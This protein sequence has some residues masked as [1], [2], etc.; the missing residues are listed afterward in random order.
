MKSIA[1]DLLALL[2]E[3]GGALGL[4]EYV[5][6][7][8]LPESGD[9]VSL[10]MA[11]T[12]RLLKSYINGRRQY[13]TA[14]NVLARSD[15]GKTSEVRLKVY[16][17]LSAVASLFEGMNRFALSAGRTILT[18]EASAPSIVSQTTDGRI[19]YSVAITIEY[20]EKI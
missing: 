14:F 18:G 9:G 12:P 15:V 19:T 6:M 2:V 20:E 11:G 5:Q 1:Y 10:Q 17:W 4:P 7:D 8:F 16:D 13:Q 3:N